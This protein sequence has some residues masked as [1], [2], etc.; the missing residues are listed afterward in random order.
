MKLLTEQNYYETIFPRIPVPVFR[1]IQARVT[2]HRLSSLCVGTG[3]TP[4]FR[5]IQA[6]VT[7]SPPPVVCLRRDWAHPRQPL[8]WG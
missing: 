6:R 2:P 1:E 3:R 8:H 4:V 5:E 7:D